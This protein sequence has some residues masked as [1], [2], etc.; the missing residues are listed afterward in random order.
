MITFISNSGEICPVAQRIQKEGNDVQVYI[1]HPNYDASFDN[2]L[3]KVKLR[4]LPSAVRKSRLVIFDHVRPNL[5]LKRDTALLRVFN[6]DQESL[7]VFGPIAE[8]IRK[9]GV[10]V[11]GASS[12]TE[13]LELDRYFG[14]QVA[15][16]CGFALP[17]TYDFKRISEAQQFLETKQS[18]WVL[19]PHNN[20]D[21]DL[22]YVEQFPGELEYK[23]RH[24]IRNRVKTDNFPLM[25]QKR[26]DGVALSTECWFNG[27]EFTVRNHTYEDKALMPGGLGPHI[28]SQSNTVWTRQDALNKDILSKMNNLLPLLRESG[29]IGPIDV[30][31]IIAEKNNKPYFLEWTPRFGYDALFCLLEL[32][33]GKYL[34]FFLNMDNSFDDRK[35]A[36]SQRISIP[37][38]PYEVPDVPLDPADTQVK[39]RAD[40]KR[41]YWQDVKLENGLLQ[42]AGADGIIGVAVSTGYSPGEAA[43]NA[44]K[45][46]REARIGAYKQFRTDHKESAYKHLEK[47]PYVQAKLGGK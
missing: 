46:C 26:I 7:S 28:G 21:L 13:Q 36:A 9:R 1:H 43:N 33:Q 19:K 37:P 32:Y 2:I 3:P 31:C 23:L 11:L 27:T 44:Y 16:Q 24:D 18:R 4:D 38:Y 6:C 29:Y 8:K 40:D 10:R 12:W 47:L 25:L 14:S 17:V 45:S 22:T 41:F 39:E 20:V 15:K 34:D 35:F 5:G 30:N 42:C